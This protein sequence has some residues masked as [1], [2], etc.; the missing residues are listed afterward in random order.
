MSSRPE[1]LAYA[2]LRRGGDRA[3]RAR[4]MVLTVLTKGVGGPSRMNIHSA[5]P[6]T[7]APLPFAAMRA[8]PYGAGE[9][10]PQTPSHREYLETYNTRVVARAY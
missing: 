4:K 1:R 6:D 10:Y 7:V 9:R 8:Y 3:I 2:G 5:S